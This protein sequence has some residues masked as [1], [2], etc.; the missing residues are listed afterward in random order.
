MRTP[1]QE[2]ERRTAAV[3]TRS[4]W[5]GGVRVVGRG[6]SRVVVVIGTSLELEGERLAASGKRR[7]DFAWSRG[8][9]KAIADLIAQHSANYSL[10]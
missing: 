5:A 3:V 7:G 4:R 8:R 9:V 1:N 10:D 2:I 6:R